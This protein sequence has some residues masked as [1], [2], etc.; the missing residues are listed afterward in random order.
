MGGGA[1]Q[2]MRR[3]SR[4]LPLLIIALPK[5]GRYVATEV[6]VQ[7]GWQLKRCKMTA[8]KG[9]HEF[10]RGIVVSCH[11]PESLHGNVPCNAYTIFVHRD[12]GEAMVSFAR[13]VTTWPIKRVKEEAERAGARWQWKGDT[14]QTLQECMDCGVMQR[15][16]QM[17][18]S[19]SP[20]MVSPRCNALWDYKDIIQ[21]PPEWL[22]AFDIPPDI[23]PWQKAM[24][25]RT[26][27]S[28][29]KPP[30]TRD[31]MGA[32]PDSMVEMH[33]RLEEE[34]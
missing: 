6:A 15:F 17:W 18:R 26:R 24:K 22:A 9:R 1:E 8:W 12:M 28:T 19:L 4:H 11:L 2:L 29:G 5:C 10:P 34:C 13:Y 21:G 16:E 31:S 25:T 7:Y 30:T 33:E 20:W 23:E 32:W 27:T 14:P 3:R